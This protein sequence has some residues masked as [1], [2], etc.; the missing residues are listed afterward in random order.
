MEE[1]CKVSHFINI[2]TVE[3]NTIINLDQIR[4]LERKPGESG[5]KLHF[6]E[7]HTMKLNGKAADELLQIIATSEQ[8]IGHHR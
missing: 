3:G 5:V 2:Q 7:T 8:V 4:Y 6:S 1:G